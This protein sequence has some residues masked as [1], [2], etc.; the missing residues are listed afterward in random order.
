MVFDE[1]C[2]TSYIFIA[3]YSQIGHEVAGVY[4]EKRDFVQD[5]MKNVQSREDCS[6]NRTITHR[7]NTSLYKTGMKVRKS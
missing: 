7:S 2:L 4:E 5:G 3:R 6:S 1:E